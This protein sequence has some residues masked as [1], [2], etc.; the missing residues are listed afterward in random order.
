MLTVNRATSC[1]NNDDFPFEKKVLVEAIR[2]FLLKPSEVGTT[3]TGLLRFVN[4]YSNRNH[5]SKERCSIHRATGQQ[6]AFG[7]EQKKRDDVFP[8]ASYV[9]RANGEWIVVDRL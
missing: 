7:I 9:D 8:V 3:F 5:L 6:A 1:L 4:S 2:E